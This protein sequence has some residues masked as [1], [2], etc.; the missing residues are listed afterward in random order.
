MQPMKGALSMALVV[1]W[2]LAACGTVTSGS[3]AAIYSPEMLAQRG[4]AF[5]G[6]VTAVALRDD[7]VDGHKT[8][9]VTFKVNRWYRGGARD[10]YSMWAYTIAG[11]DGTTMARQGAR[12]LVAGEQRG[13]GPQP[14][15]GVA[16][17]CGFTQPY[18][19]EATAEWEAAL[20]T[21]AP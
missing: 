18:S 9:W 15:E 3:C 12:L 2:L 20:R 10:T 4:I 7:P 17:S 21:S 8:P 11:E 6:T 5:D 16:W 19:P 1:V 14:E 13:V